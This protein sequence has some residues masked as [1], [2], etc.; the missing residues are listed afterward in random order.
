M[1]DL[2]HS[3]CKLLAVSNS[4]MVIISANHKEL[5]VVAKPAPEFVQQQVR[6]NVLVANRPQETPKRHFSDRGRTCIC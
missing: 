3:E 4:K 2:R 5:L 6:G 1:L